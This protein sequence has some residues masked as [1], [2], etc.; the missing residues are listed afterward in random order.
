MTRDDCKKISLAQNASTG[1]PATIHHKN[2]AVDVIAGRG[3]Q[4]DGRAG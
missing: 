1:E 2:M 3:T 4:K